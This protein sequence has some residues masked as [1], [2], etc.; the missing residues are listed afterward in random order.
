MALG[1]FAL[2]AVISAYLPVTA[3][4]ILLPLILLGAV[5][6]PFYTQLFARFMLGKIA[7]CLGLWLLLVLGAYAVQTGSVT[8][9]ATFIFMP[10]GLLTFNLLL[11]NEFPDLEADTKGGRRNLVI[12]MGMH[13]AATLYASL[14]ALVYILPVLGVILGTL[15][16]SVLVGLEALPLAFKAAA[17]SFRDPRNLPSFVPCQKSNVQALLLTNAL[18]SMGLMATTMT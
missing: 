12:A 15:P 8:L 14:M 11:I 4:V 17:T 9:E 6:T 1:T 10:L 5:F 2:G 3:G 18:L 16:V 7:A 13:R